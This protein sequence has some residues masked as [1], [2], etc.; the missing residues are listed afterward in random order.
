W[1]IKANPGDVIQPPGPEPVLKDYAGRI[2]AVRKMLKDKTGYNLL[3]R[4]FDIQPNPAKVL[5]GPSE[6]Y[7]RRAIE[8]MIRGAVNAR[9]PLILSDNDTGFDIDPDTP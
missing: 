5:G 3:S 8:K 4:P 2:E 9:P 6:D 7:D 1:T